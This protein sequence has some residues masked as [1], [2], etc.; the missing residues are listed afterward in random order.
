VDRWAPADLQC[1]LPPR[2]SPP[3]GIVEGEATLTFSTDPPH[4]EKGAAV[5][6]ADGP[7]RAEH[8]PSMDL[9]TLE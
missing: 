3:A 2:C 9:V 4:P 6:H 8:C 7:F 5:G 1:C